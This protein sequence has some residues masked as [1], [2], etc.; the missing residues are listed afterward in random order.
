MT[1]MRGAPN[2]F[3]HLHVH[4]GYSMLDGSAKPE[5]LVARARELGMPALAITD[6]GNLYGV[7]DFYKA[8][9]SQGIKPIIG[10]EAYFVH[11]AN[12]K[13][14]R[15]NMHLILLAKN[16]TGYYNLNRLMTRANLEGF[17]YTP[18]IDWAMLEQHHDGL[19]ATSACIY[20]LLSR[21]ILQDNIDEAVEYAVCMQDIFGKGNYY[22]ELMYHGIE[23]E[24]RVI[25]GILE[26]HKRT[27]IPLVA[28]NDVHYS[29]K[30]DCKIRNVLCY[31]RT[32][33]SKIVDDGTL[34]LRTLQEMYEA[35]PGIPQVAFD[36]TL[37][38][39]D[40][41]DFKM[42][43]GTNHMP[44]VPDADA[45]LEQAVWDGIR[46]RY[47]D[48]PSQ[49]VIDRVNYELSVINK[50]GFAS[51]F[52][53]VQDYV[54]WAKS[55]NIPLGYG[56]GSAVGSIVA[57][58]LGITDV[59]P[60]QYNLLFERFLNPSR[61]S[62]PDIDVDFGEGRNDVIRYIQDKYG[63]ENT[64]QVL[65]IY[66]YGGKSAFR[67]VARIMNIPVA[68]VEAIQLPDSL[69]GVDIDSVASNQKI[70][71]ALTI[72]NKIE[73]LPR[74]TSV[75]AGGVVIADKPLYNYVALE[76]NTSDTIALD[77]VTQQ[78]KSGI[79]S[80]GLL[81]MDLLGLKNL[82]VVQKCKELIRRNYNIEPQI[83]INDPAIYSLLREG[84]VAGLFQVEGEGFR[85]FLLHLQPTEFSDVYA[86]L[87]LYRPG[88][89]DSGGADTYIKRKH[90]LELVDYFGVPE[91]EPILKETYGVIVYQEQVMQI[92]S[93]VA[94]YSLSEADLLRR[95]IGKKD[96]AII[97]KQRADFINRAKN[98]Q[99]AERIY[100]VIEKFA[101][102]GFNKSHAVAYAYL[103][104][105]TAWF[106][107]YYPI[108]FWTSLLQVFSDKPD[109]INYYLSEI[110][111]EYGYDYA[112]PDINLSDANWTFDG[113]VF[114][115]GLGCIKKVQSKTIDRIIQERIEH[116]PYTNLQD[117]QKR[118]KPDKSTLTGLI[119]SG[120]LENI[121]V[122]RN[123]IS[124]LPSEIEAILDSIYNNVIPP[125]IIRYP[126][127][128]NE[129]LLQRIIRTDDNNSIFV[130]VD[131]N[132][133]TYDV[134]IEDRDWLQ[135]LLQSSRRLYETALES[136]LNE[137]I[138]SRAFGAL[139]D[140]IVIKGTLVPIGASRYTLK[141]PE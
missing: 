42:Q 17:Y 46:Q 66:Y 140:N 129:Y 55:H 126:L 8:C 44:F 118:A 28:T 131:A 16:A 127:G 20:G 39:A 100:D 3:V 10:V 11:D 98:K 35:L 119:R 33:N 96:K 52:L 43:F 123:G 95:A 87:A 80:L 26:I 24:A 49:T 113:Q 132:G 141:A 21:S 88:T 4:T 128:E 92:A 69:A 47:G 32:N 72:A 25:K 54:Q 56:R 90:G 19:M 31:I 2:S 38:I 48:T 9:V 29:N 62:M 50:M 83:D 65:T 59:E 68:E 36:N 124:Q 81:K 23:Q 125:H 30:E 6:H 115:P 104:M 22:L 15:D 60:L 111:Q 37:V 103:T 45:R 121:G 73:G 41:V 91:L 63:H 94:G 14:Q 108:E 18:R 77:I 110:K 97:D 70:R 12:Q 137:R 74:H 135:E 114:R 27:G 116:G 106:K 93:A 99:I 57:Y 51:Y 7:V 67:D 130:L 40:M 122:P 105:T 85:E 112:V 109:K 136:D 139:M 102:Y 76:R 34:H 5:K 120:A 101:D 117:L 53:I 13:T 71:E 138:N 75:H 134:E 58:A 61:V 64:A 107:Y 84:K 1:K 79:E 89:L 86:A 78:D 133:N 82:D